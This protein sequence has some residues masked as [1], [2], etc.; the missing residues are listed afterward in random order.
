MRIIQ[1]KIKGCLG[2]CMTLVLLVILVGYGGYKYLTHK[3]TYY[4]Q[5]PYPLDQRGFLDALIDQKLRYDDATDNSWKSGM[6]AIKASD[7]FKEKFNAYGTGW[8]PILH[9]PPMTWWVGIMGRLSVIPNGNRQAGQITF[10]LS[11]PLIVDRTIY[12]TYLSP[13]GPVS[14]T[15]TLGK[16]LRDINNGDVVTFSARLMDYY[17][18]EISPGFTSTLPE[19]Q[20]TNRYMK[21]LSG[22]SRIGFTLM[23][24]TCAF[25]FTIRDI[26]II[27]V[28][29]P[30]A[31]PI[32]TTASSAATRV[33]EQH[34]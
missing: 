10:R 7:T 12:V 17:T 15:S 2:G 34:P 4:P 19:P 22:D 26:D 11:C 13:D 16:R 18:V 32:G 31:H 6:N 30:H 9:Q 21:E 3:P 29:P 8:S 28:T 1:D 24:D 20:A 33:D 27:K 5:L 14:P 25:E 23:G